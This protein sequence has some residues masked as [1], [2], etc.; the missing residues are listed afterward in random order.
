MRWLG[1]VVADGPGI[2]QPPLSARQ[3]FDGKVKGFEAHTLHRCRQLSPSGYTAAKKGVGAAE[4]SCG[5]G[6]DGGVGIAF[7]AE[8]RRKALVVPDLPPQVGSLKSLHALTPL[9]F[10]ISSPFL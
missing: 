7:W 4:A 8:T 9:F 6:A 10:L 5:D 2:D 3:F 1:M